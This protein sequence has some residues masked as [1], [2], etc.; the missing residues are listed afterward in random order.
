MLFKIESSYKLI[1]FNM[2]HCQLYFLEFLKKNAIFSPIVVVSSC[3][4]LT[5]QNCGRRIDYVVCILTNTGNH[6][7][8]QY[9]DLTSWPEIIVQ[10]D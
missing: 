4:L 8:R 5:H 1:I 2:K 3:F 10:W 7:T 9:E 6:C